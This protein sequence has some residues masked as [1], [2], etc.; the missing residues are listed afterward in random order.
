MENLK[1]IIDALTVLKGQSGAFAL[2][3]WGAWLLKKYVI[4]GNIAR[5]FDDKRQVRRILERMLAKMDCLIL[6]M[7]KVKEDG[8]NTEKSDLPNNND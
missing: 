7:R 2:V 3:F 8:T 5:Y 4:N 1:E 6:E